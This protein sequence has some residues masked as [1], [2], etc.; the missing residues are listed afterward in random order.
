MT[1]PSSDSGKRHLLVFLDGNPQ[2]MSRP[3]RAGIN[4]LA[5]RLPDVETIVMR[6]DQNPSGQGLDQAL[7]R[8]LAN[9]GKASLSGVT[10]LAT[11]KVT[12]SKLVNVRNTLVYRGVAAD[13]GAVPGIVVI[14]PNAE[15]YAVML[16]QSDPYDRSMVRYGGESGAKEVHFIHAKLPPNRPEAEQELID[17]VYTQLTVHDVAGLI[18]YQPTGQEEL[19]RAAL[20]VSAIAPHIASELDPQHLLQGATQALQ[21]VLRLLSNA[22]SGVAVPAPAQ[23]TLAALG[24]DA[25]E[26]ATLGAV[27]AASPLFSNPGRPVKVVDERGR[28]TWGR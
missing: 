28:V 14:N 22:G 9:R 5:T 11:N 21:R 27:M 17:Q 7:N 8:E 16:S 4:R 23:V 25:K 20:G 15:Q 10:V 26:R 12:P 1:A 19:S 18:G 6:P 3:V 24:F 13:S 2:G